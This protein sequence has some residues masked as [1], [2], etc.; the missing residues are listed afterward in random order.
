[1]YQNVRY[2]IMRVDIARIIILHCYGGLYSDLDVWPNRDIYPQVDFALARVEKT[3]PVKV[4]KSPRSGRGTQTQSRSRMMAT[5]STTT[6]LYM[7]IECII[8]SQGN[9]IMLELL[10]HI[11]NEIENKMWR[12]PTDWYHTK[13]VRYVYHTTGPRSMERFIRSRGQ[14]PVHGVRY[15]HCNCFKYESHIPPQK[16]KFFDII[17]HPSNSYFT[18]AAEIRVPV[19]EGDQQFPPVGSFWKRMRSKSTRQLELTPPGGARD[20]TGEG[21]QRGTVGDS[22]HSE[23]EATASPS[24]GSQ[25]KETHI[26]QTRLPANWPMSPGMSH[27]LQPMDT[28][29]HRAMSPWLSIVVSAETNEARHT[30]EMI[31]ELKLY[32]CEHTMTY[33]SLSMDPLIGLCPVP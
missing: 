7:D 11:S 29:I 3:V 5:Q 16:R 23:I 21:S 25:P 27:L 31:S 33:A 6:Q 1:M 8:A 26:P 15:L 28:F 2:P 10:S 14:G 19:G 4:R 9:P 12:R 18:K 24:Q 22:I 20:S 17:S 13:R 30:V 32:F